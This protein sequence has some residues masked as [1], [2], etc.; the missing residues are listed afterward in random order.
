VRDRHE[1]SAYAEMAID[2]Q[3]VL[4][5]S[6]IVFLKLKIVDIVTIN[7]GRLGPPN[8]DPAMNGLVQ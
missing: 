5:I 2:C 8:L 7:I 3:N 1:I 4:N 6:Y